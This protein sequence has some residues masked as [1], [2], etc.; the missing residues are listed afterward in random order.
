MNKK[1]YS[2]IFLYKNN[3]DIYEKYIY[4]YIRLFNT[5]KWGLC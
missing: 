2:G 4:I 1:M 5:T 3:G